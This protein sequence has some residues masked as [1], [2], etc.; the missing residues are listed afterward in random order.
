V[1]GLLTP[2]TWSLWEIA[3]E[4]GTRAAFHALG[5]ASRA[6]A[7]VPADRTHGFIRAFH[8]RG[9]A[10]LEFL[11]AMGD[12]IPGTSGAA[13]A[14]QVFGAAPPALV[15]HPSRLRSGRAGPG[16]D[17]PVATLL[18]RVRVAAT[19]LAE[20]RDVGNPQSEDERQSSGLDCLLVRVGDQPASA[21]TAISASLCAATK[22]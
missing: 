9:A 1:P 19:A 8:G 18:T 17:Q 12:R 10:Q 5:A 2:L 3:A 22:E 4:G 21:T 13:I 6:E 7:E 20:R 14:E 15:G 16:E 11:C